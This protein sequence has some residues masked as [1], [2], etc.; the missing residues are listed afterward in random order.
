VGKVPVACKVISSNPVY[1]V[2]FPCYTSLSNLLQTFRFLSHFTF[3][4]NTVLIRFLRGLVTVS[5][6][7]VQH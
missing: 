4:L 6:L 1:V 3:S 5:R 2:L 7:K